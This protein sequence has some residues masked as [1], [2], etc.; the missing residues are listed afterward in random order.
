[1]G[2][3]SLLNVPNRIFL[4]VS[5]CLLP[6]IEYSQCPLVAALHNSI[7]CRPRPPL[8][9]GAIRKIIELRLDLSGSVQPDPALDVVILLFI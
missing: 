9:V 3:R 2:R 8:L 7:L 1:M 5:V 4:C 6:V